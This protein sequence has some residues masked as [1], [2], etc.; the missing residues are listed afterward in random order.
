MLTAVDRKTFK[1]CPCCGHVWLNR[2]DFLNDGQVAVLGY[3]ANF[4]HLSIGFILFNHYECKTTMALQAGDFIDL[5]DGPIFSE[6]KR[7][8]AGC[9]AYC[10]S[11][12]ELRPC[13][14]PCECAY[15]REVI[16]VIT[17]WGHN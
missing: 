4:D 5:Y 14:Q 6:N 10:L 17:N 15:V 1:S 7:G 2:E 3:Q 8:S 16:Q 12:N 9:P 11:V 13:V